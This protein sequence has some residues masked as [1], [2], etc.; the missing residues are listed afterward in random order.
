MLF[1]I[2]YGMNSD[3]EHIINILK[4]RL[5]QHKEDKIKHTVFYIYACNEKEFES[6]KIR[7]MNIC[8]KDDKYKNQIEFCYTKDFGKFESYIKGRSVQ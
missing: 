8:G 3:D 6:E 7:I 1:V 4:E 5:E 2:G